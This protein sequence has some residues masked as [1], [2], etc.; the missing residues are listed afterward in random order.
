MIFYCTFPIGNLTL[1]PDSMFHKPI[2]L[3]KESHLGFYFLFC[4][5]FKN[6]T[7]ISGDSNSFLKI[8]MFK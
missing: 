7:K 6:K 4:F 5:P 8:K 1:G 2:F 3:N